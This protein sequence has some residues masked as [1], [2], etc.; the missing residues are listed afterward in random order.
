VTVVKE[1]KLELE[2]FN[3]EM[4]EEGAAPA[5]AAEEAGEGEKA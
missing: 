1:E 2:T 3:P 4:F 5:A